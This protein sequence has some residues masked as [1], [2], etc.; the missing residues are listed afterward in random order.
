GTRELARRPRPC[1]P[2]QRVGQG[3][4]R[5]GRHQGRV[6]G[7]RRA[8]PA[9][10]HRGVRAGRPGARRLPRALPRAPPRAAE[11]AARAQRGRAGLRR[12]PGGDRGGAA[13]QDVRGR[14]ARGRQR[15]G[16]GAARGGG[17]RQVGLALRL[18]GSRG[19]FD[20]RRARRARRAHDRVQ[21]PLARRH[22]R[23]LGAGCAL[24]A[25]GLPRPCRALEARL[26]ASGALPGRLRVVLRPV[27]P[28]HA[29]HGARAGGRGV[30]F[31]GG[32]PAMSAVAVPR[33]RLGLVELALSTDH[34]RVATRLLGVA[35]LLFLGG[36][37]MAL[38]MRLELAQPGLQVVSTASYN[39]LFTMHGSTMIYLVITP[40]ALALGVYLVP[41][42]VGAAEIA[43]PRLALGGLWL[44]VLG[45]VVM[46][47]G[48]LTAGG[49]GRATWIG[50]NPLSEMVNSP[51]V[52]MDLW[53]FGVILATAGELALGVCI[54]L[55][56]L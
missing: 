30:R 40:A 55:T 6:R 45:G 21:R 19:A 32:K 27:P 9:D 34:K 43:A 47:S 31:L 42:Q 16:G 25:P 33:P 48:F 10:R 35:L 23:L 56:A 7:S 12:R 26:P 2:V 24:P 4:A 8:L 22:P 44:I 29:L 15:R 49:P 50:V 53:I 28:G 13:R 1:L 20:A 14:V 3:T 46:E 54:L 51:G 11:R 17:R 41:L 52:G 18:S 39:A 38:V 36:G 5:R 37:V